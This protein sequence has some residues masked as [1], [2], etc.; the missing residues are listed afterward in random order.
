MYD[1]IWFVITDEASKQYFEELKAQWYE[2]GEA[3]Q[4]VWYGIGG[5]DTAGCKNVMWYYHQYNIPERWIRID[6]FANNL[7]YYGENPLWMPNTKNPFVI[8]GNTIANKDEKRWPSY[9][10]EYNTRSEDDIPATLVSQFPDKVSLY[11]MEFIKTPE[12]IFSN[13]ITY[14]PTDEPNGLPVMMEVK[15]HLNKL[16]YYTITQVADAC[17]P[18]PCGMSEHNFEYF[19]K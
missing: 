9:I 3:D 6:A 7:P 11:N 18:W 5:N 10:I 19:L 13:G 17:A 16:Y 1:E 12:E 8:S 15:Y 14:R 2:C 4:F